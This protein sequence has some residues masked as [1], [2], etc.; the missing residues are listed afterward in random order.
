LP[1]EIL[2][3]IF[4]NLNAGDLISIS[5]VCHRW[6][7][8]SLDNLLWKKLYTKFVGASTKEKE[9][10]V[11]LHELAPGCWKNL[12][13]RR[14]KAKRDQIYFKKWTLA[15]PY[16]GLKQRADQTL[17]KLGVCFEL[18]LINTEGQENTFPHCDICWSTM[19]VG[20]QWYALVVPDI[21]DIHCIRVRACTPLMFYGPSKPAKD[22]ILQ[23]S[24]L[25]EYTGRIRDVLQKQTPLGSEPQIQL[26]ELAPG[27][28]IAK[29]QADG[30]IAFVTCT[31]HYHNLVSR[32]LL[33]NPNR[34]WSSPSL[35]CLNDD[36]DPEYGLHG[37]TCIIIVRNMR[38]KF[39]EC[40]F[41]E[42]HTSIE[43]LADGFAVFN[44][45]KKDD[46]LSHVSLSKE[47]NFSWRTTLFKGVLKDVGILDLTL[48]DQNGEPFW[49]VSTGISVER[50]TQTNQ[51]DFNPSTYKLIQ[52]SDN[53]GKLR[54]E[55]GK[56]DDR[57]QYLS[58]ASLSLSL[59]VI[60][61]AF[62]R[63]YQ[64]RA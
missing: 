64:T 18:S 1:D 23:K 6:H 39:L 45:V 9:D 20:V 38:T 57:R 5:Q 11:S 51:F 36:I 54:L 25:L 31:L 34:I 58:D 10:K 42:L 61:K 29:Y 62:K 35:S 48:L 44:P 50:C 59:N 3:L 56:L 4:W 63:N 13:L 41:T 43:A 2:S 28:L 7:R 52:Y 17:S 19:S 37:Y 49:I 60:N 14:C 26:F 46:K 21:K 27:L 16:T 12:C 55:I 8:V 53:V 30:E 22:G 47:I 40:R 33:G 15:D 32:C 24:K